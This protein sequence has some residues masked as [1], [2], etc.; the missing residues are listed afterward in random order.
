MTIE[1]QIENLTKQRNQIDAK[2]DRLKSQIRE[3]RVET[4]FVHYSTIRE[5]EWK[6][7]VLSSNEFERNNTV[8]VAHSKAELLTS[9][10]QLCDDMEKL[11]EDLL[12]TALGPQNITA[13]DLI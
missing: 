11:K 12:N 5:D 13:D 2:I 8:I 3:G 4:R 9:L 10:I 1:E 6:L 7:V